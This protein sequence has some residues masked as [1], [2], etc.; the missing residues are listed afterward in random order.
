MPHHP[1]HEPSLARLHVHI[2]PIRRQRPIHPETAQEL[3]SR[4]I[5]TT[6]PWRHRV[7]QVQDIRWSAHV[8]RPGWQPA[9]IRVPRLGKVGPVRHDGAAERD[10]CSRRRR[11]IRPEQHRIRVEIA[12]DEGDLGCVC[13]ERGV[14][15]RVGEGV[16]PD[17][18]G[19]EAGGAVL[20]VDRREGL[21]A[22]DH[23]S[24][25]GVGG[26]IELGGRRVGVEGLEVGEARLEVLLGDGL[27][28]GGV[29]VGKF[30][31]EEERLLVGVPAGQEGHFDLLRVGEGGGGHVGQGVV[32]DAGR[33]SSDRGVGVLRP[34][35]RAVE[36]LGRHGAELN[37]GS[38][39][40]FLLE[41]CALLPCLGVA[42]ER[43][44]CAVPEGA[45][46]Y[47]GFAEWSSGLGR[48]HEQAN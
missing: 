35:C 24:D 43:P 39:T 22:D 31:G 2:P 40:D 34:G 28:L 8:R 45:A 5:L 21:L 25:K 6:D 14:R 18:A 9:P 17:G 12:K 4:C 27:E 44:G 41:R 13:G 11:L 33:E 26:N 10:V 30:A 46:L 15:R 3:E 48:R 1:D 29:G 38:G 16:G 7:P 36:C 19:R 42:V 47:D 23:V 20:H 37:N 32:V